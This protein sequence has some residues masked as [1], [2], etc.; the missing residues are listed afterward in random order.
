[1]PEFFDTHAHLDFKDFG[2]DLDRV[3]ARARAAGVAR[4][5]S[6]GSGRR[7]ASAAA[8]VTLAESHEFIWATVATFRASIVCF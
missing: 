2:G 3:L 8:A 6:I 5:I 4:M 7:T 1:M